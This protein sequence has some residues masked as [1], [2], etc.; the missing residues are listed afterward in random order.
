VKEIAALAQGRKGAIRYERSNSMRKRFQLSAVVA[1]F[2]LVSML[3][4]PTSGQT[5][6]VLDLTAARAARAQRSESRVDAMPGAAADPGVIAYVRGSTHDIHVISPD[7]SGDRVLWGAPHPLTVYPAFDLAW[8]P[9]GRELAFSSDHEV[10]CSWYESD[11][12]AIGYN[13]AGYRRVTNSPACAALVGLPKGSVVVNVN[14]LTSSMV[15]AY[16]Q[17]APGVQTVPYGNSTVTF[18]DV[19]DFGPGAAQPA[20]GIWGGVR[21]MSSPPLADVQ[22]GATVPGGSIIISEYS[23]IEWFGAGKVSWKADSSALAYGMRTYSSISQILAV[24][25]YGSIGEQLPVVQHAGPGLVAWGPTLA[26]KNQYLY[27][28]LSSPFADNIDGIYLN[29]VGDTSGGTKLVNI[30]NFDGQAVWDIEWLPDASGFLFIAKYFSNVMFDFVSE[31]F[32]Y[33]FDPPG[34]TQLTDFGDAGARELSI[35]PDGQHVVFDR[36]DESDGTS[37][38]WII[39]RNNTG[40]H[41]LAADA[42]HP[43]WGRTPAPLDKR[44]YLPLVVK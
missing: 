23:G 44:V 42:G 16:V 43:A 25:H 41:K 22:P 37:S 4:V 35:S 9:D 13:G 17:G 24:P 15:Q 8:R 21:F 1:A 39:N 40:L 20:V 2:V 18:H 3:A 14:N 32:E 33:T 6:T 11:V 31:I 5:P 29:T 27:Y 36:V 28:S 34:L 10:A 12:Y 26:T 38:L 19:A 30:Y 7:G